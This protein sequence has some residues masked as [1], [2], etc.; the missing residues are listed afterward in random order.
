MNSKLASTIS[1]V[2]HPLLVTTYLFAML[3]YLFPQLVYT[4]K[5]DFKFQF[6]VTVFILTFILPGLC[7][8]ILVKT[9]WSSSI[10]MERKEDRVYPFLFTIVLYSIATYMF[11]SIFKSDIYF[12]IIIGFITLSMTF[13]ALITLW[14][15]ISAHASAM[16]GLIAFYIVSSYLNAQQ[17]DL[18]LCLTLIFIAGIT[19]SSRLALNS[20]NLQQVVAGFLLG[21]LT[22]LSSLFILIQI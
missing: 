9:G 5:E 8:L 20:H 16:G 6:I 21:L 12:S 7:S 18:N 22:G 1:Y 13:V 3:V 4:I 15:K 10:H 14:W 19:I 17:F 2:F 11:Y